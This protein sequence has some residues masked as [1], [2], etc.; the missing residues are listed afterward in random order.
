MSSDLCVCECV[1]TYWGGVKSLKGEG[2]LGAEKEMSVHVVLQGVL[3]ALRREALL[4]NR[5]FL[6][7][8]GG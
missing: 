3:A 4:T 6:P 8:R 1:S 2:V 7:G 5:T